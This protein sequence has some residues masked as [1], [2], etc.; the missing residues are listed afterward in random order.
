MPATVKRLNSSSEEINA[1]DF[2]YDSESRLSSGKTTN[3][4][5]VTGATNSY[6]AGYNYDNYGRLQNY[7]YPSG[8]MITHTYNPYPGELAKIES[9]SLINNNL[10]WQCN[11]VNALGQITQFNKS[12]VVTTNT[13]NPTTN[14]LT[15]ITTPSNLINQ[16]YS[17]NNK[18]Q[19][20]GRTDTRNGLNLQETFTY[21]ALNR[22]H[23]ITDNLG[24]VETLNFQDNRNIQDKNNVGNYEYDDNKIH[25]L[26]Q[27]TQSNN[28]LTNM[29]NKLLTQDTTYSSFGI[30]SLF[31]FQK[32]YFCQILQK[33]V[34]F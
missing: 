28:D 6:I 19:L 20:S 10:I 17:Y 11:T 31:R 26:S 34:R 12:V 14:L 25:A 16:H 32:K 2:T 4:N 3:K 24:N 30:Q 33:K 21:D 29:P 23:T 13:D 5:V 1:Q 9:P 27:I 18:L 8:F 7:T 22:L 15:D